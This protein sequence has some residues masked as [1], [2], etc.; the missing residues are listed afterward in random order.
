MWRHNLKLTPPCRPTLTPRTSFEVVLDVDLGGPGAVE[1]D[2]LCEE[3][4]EAGDG[5]GVVD[6]IGVVCGGE[7][8]P[9]L[10]WGGG[11]AD[12][13][14]EDGVV[15]EV[16]VVDLDVTS[17]VSTLPSIY[18]FTA[19]WRVQGTH[20]D[21]PVRPLNRGSAHFDIFY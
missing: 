10:G 18:S 7:G 5:D 16:C 17:S 6:G 11:D 2:V 13:A 9:G 21:L 19:R 1:E 3:L 12:C 20:S 15:L 4:G 14:V 8:D